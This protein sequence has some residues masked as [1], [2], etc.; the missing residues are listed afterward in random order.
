MEE[1]NT[2]GM[3]SIFVQQEADWSEV[4]TQ[5]EIR[6]RYHVSNSVNDETFV[7]E[8]E[9]N[10]VQ[11][12]R[13]YRAL[14][15]HI[16]TPIGNPVLKAKRL[17][18]FYFH[19]MQISDADG[20]YLGAIKRKFS[21]F[22]NQYTIEGSDGRELFKIYGPF[23]HPYTFNILK[24][25]IQIGQIL[26]TWNGLAKEALTDADNFTAN[27]PVDTEPSHKALFLGALFLIDLVHFENK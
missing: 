10:Y 5:Y 24:N 7:V 9:S 4:I 1:M 15:L 3:E 8:E 21:L 19:E 22:S 11:T 13:N 20:E 26:K 16:L 25:D 6:N 17:F 2:S 14:T 23:F 18:K 12:L 27:F